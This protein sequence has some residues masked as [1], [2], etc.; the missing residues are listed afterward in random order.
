MITAGIDSIDSPGVSGRH[1]EV[2]LSIAG[3]PSFVT[4]PAKRTEPAPWVWYAPTF[5]DGDLRLPDE[6]HEWLFA[7][8]LSRGIAI[9]GIDVGDS[10]GSPAGC[11]AFADF[12]EVVTERFDLAAKPSLLAQSRGALMH[13]AW[14]A[15]HPEQVR[16]IA[17]IYP[18]CDLRSYPG[19][20]AAAPSYELTPSE[21]ESELAQHN[22]INILQPLAAAGVPIFH[23]HGDADDVVPLQDNTAV[24]AS[25]YRALGGS[26]TVVIVPDLGHE[27]PPCPEFFESREL[28]AF[29]FGP[30]YRVTA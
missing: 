3:Q 17:C 29:L 27:Y 2:R 8:L 11:E 24:L 30:T 5:L 21:L 4:I 19:I 1:R 9:A 26:I 20:D 28:A 7:E 22:P 14:A 13:Y 10:Y 12:H 15:R 6:S 25:R 16:A 18:V 23:V